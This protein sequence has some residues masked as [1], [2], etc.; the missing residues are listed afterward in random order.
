MKGSDEVK[1]L[2]DKYFEGNTSLQEEQYLRNY[3]SFQTVD[4]ELVEYTP[5]FRYFKKERKSEQKTN[6]FYGRSIMLRSLVSAAA[7][8]LLILGVVL[9]PSNRQ[10][11][12]VVEDEFGCTGTY[13]RIEGTCYNDITL[14]FSHA[15][16]AISDL[17]ILLAEDNSVKT[18]NNN[19]QQ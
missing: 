2:L 7:C 16:Q 8:V 14:V 17:D 19:G 12:E 9:S 4:K 15:A 10:T 13:V 6:P 3:F 5:I 18:I 11:T 1:K